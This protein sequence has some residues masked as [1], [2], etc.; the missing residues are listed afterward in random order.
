MNEAA[1]KPPSKICPVSRA[2][3]L[4][5]KHMPINLIDYSTVKE[6]E[7]GRSLG[8]LCDD[9]WE[10]PA[11]IEELEKW[12]VQNHGNLPKGSYVAD[13]GYSPRPGAAGGGAVISTQAMS[14]MVAIGME[15]Y[16]S[17]YPEFEDE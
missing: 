1:Q 2:L 15:L 14:I 12:L 6:G 13:V 5:D 7:K 10:L 8:G 9:E 16:L 11:Q 3:G 4:Q 17:E